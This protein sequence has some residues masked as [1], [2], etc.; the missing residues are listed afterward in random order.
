MN[1]IFIV[2]VIIAAVLFWFLLSFVFP[3]L[4]RLCYRL[5]SDTKYNLNKDYKNEEEKENEE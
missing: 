3:V 4:G 1:P 2:L 5:W